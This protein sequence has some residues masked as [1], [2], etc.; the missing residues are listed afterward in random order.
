M[1]QSSSTEYAMQTRH[2][3]HYNLCFAWAHWCA[4]KHLTVFLYFVKR[5][6]HFVSVSNSGSS[7]SFVAVRPASFVVAP[8]CLLLRLSSPLVGFEIVESL[9]LS[10]CPCPRGVFHVYVCVCVYVSLLAWGSCV[11]RASLH[12]RVGCVRA[13]VVFL[14]YVLASVHDNDP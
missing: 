2:L 10:A 13:R 1:F 14:L 7:A 5:N 6:D 9:S 8:P 3:H 4:P 12:V 11:K